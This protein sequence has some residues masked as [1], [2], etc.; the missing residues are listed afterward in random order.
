MGPTQLLQLQAILGEAAGVIEDLYEHVQVSRK[1]QP[2]V[3]KKDEVL[4][5][6]QAAHDLLEEEVLAQ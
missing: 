2:L 6:L 4:A 1:L 5:R 3:I